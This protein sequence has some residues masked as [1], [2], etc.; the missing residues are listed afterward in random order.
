MMEEYQSIMKNDV[1]EIV[2]RPE[3]NSMVSLR[4][5]YKMKHAQ[6]AASRSTKHDSW[7]KD[8][9]KKREWITRRLLLQWPGTLLLELLFLLLL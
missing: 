8:S 3:G 1:W 5:N 6:M 4:W 2:L 7:P 9:L